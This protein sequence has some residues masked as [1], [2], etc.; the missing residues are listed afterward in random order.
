MLSEFGGLAFPGESGWGNDSVSDG[1]ELVRR[2]G[3]LWGAMRDCA[4][5]SGACWTQL[6]DTYQEVKGLLSF[7]R[8]PKAPLEELRA[9]IAGRA[10][11]A[12]E[13]VQPAKGTRGKPCPMSRS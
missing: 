13:R 1:A 7:D 11:L 12:P 4:G 9:G 3:D 2:V 10:N 8:I 5:L 6:T